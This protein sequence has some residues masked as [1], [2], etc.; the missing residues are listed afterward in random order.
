MLTKD[1]VK[2]FCDTVITKHSTCCHIFAEDNKYIW[3]FVFGY[4]DEDIPTIGVKEAFCFRDSNSDEYDI[5]WHMPSKDGEVDNT[6]CFYTIS[7][8]IVDKIVAD[9]P[10]HNRDAFRYID[11]YVGK[12][13]F[14]RRGD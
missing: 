2:N 6:E 1:I 12:Y 11:E 7:D 3:A 9:I 14:V 4:L 8:N 5:D 13:E 10:L